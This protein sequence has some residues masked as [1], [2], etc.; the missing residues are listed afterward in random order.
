MRFDNDDAD[1]VNQKQRLRFVGFES[2]RRRLRRRR[3]AIETENAFRNVT[4]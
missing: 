3:V 1:D 4:V 2:T